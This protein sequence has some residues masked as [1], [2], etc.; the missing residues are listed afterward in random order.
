MM[1]KIL[2]SGLVVLLCVV[3]FYSTRNSITPYLWKIKNQ[4]A[5]FFSMGISVKDL[6]EKYKSNEDHKKI[7][8]LLVPGHEPNFGGSEYGMLKER[9]LNLLISEKI[10]GILGENKK[11]EIITSR[12]FNGWNSDLEKYVNSNR[13]GI[14]SWVKSMKDEMF[15]LVDS[16]KF[17]I[18][19]AKMGHSTAPLN[20]AVFLYGINKW[21]ADNKI[22]IAIHL[23]F[24][25]NPKYKGKPN[26][27]GFSIYVP[28]KQYSNSTSSK[29]LANDLKDE[30]SKVQKVSTMK[31]ESAGVIEDQEL[32]A[33]GSYNTSDSLSVLIEY[34]YIYEDF[35]QNPVLRN[36]F[37]ER[38]AFFTSQAV[39]EFFESRI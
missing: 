16:G 29:I 1:K 38:A 28:E 26:Y 36:N 10:K 33:L 14:L 39:E 6:V 19:N 5:A 25:D 17:N 4:A 24:N 22:D 35:M 31:E 30:I 11:F 32:I 37:I 15:K 23:H 13:D 20:S 8:I 21:S 34:A 9:D 2:I 18:V 7:K 12:N 3:F 27:E